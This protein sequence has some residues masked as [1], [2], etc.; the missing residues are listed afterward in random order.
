MSFSQTSSSSS[1]ATLQVADPGLQVLAPMYDVRC[2]VEFVLGT[3]RITIRACLRLEPQ[4]VIRLDQSAGSDLSVRVCNV[5]I[6]AGE[7][8]I[9]DDTSALRVSRVLPPVGVEAE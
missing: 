4:S 1:E 2:P 9:S 6:V 8:V 3:G 7:V 5:S